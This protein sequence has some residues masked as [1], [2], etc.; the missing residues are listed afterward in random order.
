MSRPPITSFLLSLSLF[1]VADAES[2]ARLAE[3]VPAARADQD[4]SRRV[5]AA[6]ASGSSA[7][8]RGVMLN[9]QAGPPVPVFGVLLLTAA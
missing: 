7:G 4:R 1:V 9:D 2:D 6:D 5:R 3:I 8:S